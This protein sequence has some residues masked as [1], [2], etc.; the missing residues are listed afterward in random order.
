MPL[1]ID[2]DILRE[3]NLSE[4]DARIEIACRLYESGRLALPVA[5]RLSGLDPSAF[6]D[7]LS[8]R[9]ACVD[10]REQS[11]LDEQYARGYTRLPEDPA[12]STALLPHLEPPDKGWT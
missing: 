2:D 1:I 4:A 7:A 6:L 9:S 11:E 8:A 10:P 12:G 5:S 3:A